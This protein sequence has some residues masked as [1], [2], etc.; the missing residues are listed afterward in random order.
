MCTFFSPLLL[1]YTSHN[2]SRSALPYPGYVSLHRPENP[3]ELINYPEVDYDAQADLLFKLAGQAALKFRTYFNEDDLMNVVQYNKREIG[4]YIYSQLME[5]FYCETPGFEK[6][7]VKPFTKIEEHNFLKYT[8]DSIH[9]FTE[10][11]NPTSSIPAKVFSGFRKACHILYKFNSKTE[12]DFAIILEQDKAV[13]KWLR[14][15]QNQFHIYW[16]HNSRRYFPDFAAETSDAI[17]MIET[18]K[19]GAIEEADVQEKTQ[20]A[21]EY[22]KNATE[23]TTLNG[24]KP[25]KYILIP[26]NAVQMNMSFEHLVRSFEV[27]RF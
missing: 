23:F 25:W 7:V 26:H 8:K 4:R 9:H 27:Y 24:G 19:E 16:R 17:Y 5:H 20:A 10:T 15:A 22:C 14:P 3:N 1:L 2:I 13:L 18:K 11:I 21:L 6:P 12:K